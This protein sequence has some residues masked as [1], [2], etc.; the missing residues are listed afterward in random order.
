M[1]G[2]PTAAPSSLH[3]SI[4]AH[5]IHF[6]SLLIHGSLYLS[7]TCYPHLEV[8]SLSIVLF[9]VAYVPVSGFPPLFVFTAGI[10]CSRASSYVRLRVIW[11]S[12][13]SLL[14]YMRVLT[15][16]RH[17]SGYSRPCPLAL[18]IHLHRLHLVLR[19]DGEDKLVPTKGLRR[20]ETRVILACGCQMADNK[21]PWLTT[22]KYGIPFAYYVAMEGLCSTTLLSHCSPDEG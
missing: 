4:C 3:S 6:H 14:L 7:S 15:C 11:L 1:I 17:L 2:W 22:T 18:Q 9:P 21:R 13:P 5:C 10:I 16:R 12:P 20:D 19:V 8:L